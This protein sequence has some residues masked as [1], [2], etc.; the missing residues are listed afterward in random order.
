LNEGFRA[1][2]VGGVAF[3]H[4]D[5]D[6][7]RTRQGC[8][9][10]RDQ[11]VQGLLARQAPVDRTLLLVAVDLPVHGIDVHESDHIRVREQVP[12]TG[13]Q[14]DQHCSQDRLQLFD[15]AVGERAQE[16]PARGD[17]P[18][19][20][21]DFPHRAVPQPR[22]VIETVSPADHARDDGEDFRPWVRAAAVG[23]VPDLDPFLDQPTQIDLLGQ[24]H[25][26]GQAAIG[27]EVRI[28]ELNLRA[29]GAVG[30]SHLAGASLICW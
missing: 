27:Q 25:D 20:G 18:A 8:A 11:G 9:D 26:L 24:A 29:L 16:R 3:T 15:V 6:Q 28:V 30:Y 14:R 19:T 12:G 2:H 23:R 17:R 5:P 7:D 1:S 13:D 10:R 22:Q 4:P 21:E